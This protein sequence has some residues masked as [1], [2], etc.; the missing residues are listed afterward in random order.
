[1]LKIFSKSKDTPRIKFDKEWNSFVVVRNSNILYTG[2]KE[3]CE[4]YLKNYSFA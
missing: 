2:T 4:M 3:Q 1:M